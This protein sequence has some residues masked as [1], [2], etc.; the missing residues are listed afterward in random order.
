VIVL[1]ALLS[2]TLVGCDRD[3]DPIDLGPPVVTSTLGEL[4]VTVEEITN[5]AGVQ[6]ASW[7][8]RFGHGRSCAIA[9]FD[10]DGMPDLVVGHPSEESYLLLNRSTLGDVRFEPGPVLIDGALSW[11]IQAADYDNDGDVDLFFGMGGIE[12]EQLD[13]MARNEILPDGRSGFTDVSREA[14]VM[15]PVDAEG[16]PRAS[17]TAGAAFGDIDLDGDLDLLL[18]QDV[19]PLRSLDR[20][21]PTDPDG[22]NNLYQN[23]GDGTFVD[24]ARSLGL[25]SQEPSRFSTLLDIDEDGDLDIYENNYTR[26]GRLWRNRLAETGAVGFEDVTEAMS[27]GGGNIG[28][29]PET[30]VS[31]AADFN[32]D[33]YED[34]ILFVRGY[35]SSGPYTDGHVLLLNVGGRGFVDASRASKLN[36]PFDA[37]LQQRDHAYLG[38]MGSIPTDLTGNGLPDVVIGNGGPEAGHPDQLFLAES[39]VEVDFG[40][41]GLLRVPQFV[42]RTEL[43]DY[44]VPE[45]P[46]VL[47][48]GITYPQYPYR[49]HGMCA[50]DF[51]LDGVVELFV[52]EGGTPHWGGDQ[53][54]EPDRMFRFVMDPPQR[55]LQVRPRGDGERVNR[56]G[57]GARVAVRVVD[58][59]G[60][61]RSVHGTLRGSNAFSSSNVFSVFLG[62]GQAERIIDV[63]VRWTD[64][65]RTVLEDV[66]LDQVLEVHR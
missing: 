10:L 60:A 2:S 58:A 55:W 29:P 52:S 22:W 64:G 44:P 28:Y 39:L 32:Q 51:D 62:L 34:L 37:G 53:S 66:A 43:I 57:I 36:S 35:P 15:G 50:A 16:D 46:E 7:L 54:R 13:R 63:E 38:V 65:E 45:A 33:G 49:T 41:L 30:F 21:R 18:S 42:N 48:A 6:T 8:G 14:G 26:L 61:E 3:R 56:D 11:T 59:D 20:L 31:G 47:A 9:D 25:L 5:T 1:L 19:W 17:P 24:R 27:L 23:E 4:D 40:D 12:G